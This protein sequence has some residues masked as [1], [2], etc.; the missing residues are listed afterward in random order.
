M[1]QRIQTV[2]LLLGVVALGALF[3]FDGLWQSATAEAYGWFAPVLIGLVSL[4]A[5]V[6]LV[7]IFLYQN[8]PRQRSVVLGAQ[9]LT[10]LML[11][12]LYGG[13][14]LGGELSFMTK[15]GVVDPNKA[16]VLILPIGAYVMY[17]LARRAIDR[18]IELIRSMDRLR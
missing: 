2:Y 14:F 1:I 16:L 13:L 3:L 10:V 18:D 7:A 9:V 15:A 12:V 4:A 8:R 17:Y 6:G 11:I 5:L